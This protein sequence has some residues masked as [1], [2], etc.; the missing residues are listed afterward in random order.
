VDHRPK[1]QAAEATSAAERLEI[2]DHVRDRTPPPPLRRDEDG[3]G[4]PV[5]GNRNPLA[6]G[7]LLEQARELRLGFIDAD[8]LHGVLRSDQTLTRI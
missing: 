7:H 3:H 5:S 4:H 1:R 6:T 2:G 8:P